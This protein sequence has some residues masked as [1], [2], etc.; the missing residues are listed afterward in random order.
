MGEGVTKGGQLAV[1]FVEGDAA[2]LGMF[3]ELRIEC[4][5]P[6][7][8]LALASDQASKGRGDEDISTMTAE[9]SVSHQ[10]ARE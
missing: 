6:G 5:E 3:L 7:L 8:A 4:A 10:F 1:G 9:P 2:V